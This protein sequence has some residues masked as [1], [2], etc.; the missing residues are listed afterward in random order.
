[1][2]THGPQTKLGGLNMRAFEVPA[3]GAFQLMDYVPEMEALLQPGHDVADCRTPHEGGTLAR[4]YLADPEAR[5][6]ITREGHARV[7][8]STHTGTACKRC[9]QRFNAQRMAAQCRLLYNHRH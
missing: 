4:A 6:R 2:N 1:M 5:Q 3:C 9:W 8:P 7:R